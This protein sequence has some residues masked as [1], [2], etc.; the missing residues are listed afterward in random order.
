M[1]SIHKLLGG[2]EIYR[3]HPSTTHVKSRKIIYPPGGGVPTKREG[4]LFLENR[5][6]LVA[7]KHVGGYPVK[8][9]FCCGISCKTL[10]TWCSWCVNVCTWGVGYGG[11]TTE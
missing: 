9:Y 8:N 11:V 10:C 3:A 5:M 2:V 1:W 4:G 7:W 6:S